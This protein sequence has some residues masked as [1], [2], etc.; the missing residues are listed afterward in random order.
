M[1]E[2]FADWFQRWDGIRLGYSESSIVDG[3]NL[4]CTLDGYGSAG[5]SSIIIGGITGRKQYVQLTGRGVVGVDSEHGDLLWIYNRIANDVA[6]TPTPIVKGDYI[7][8][9]PGYGTGAALIQIHDRNGKYEVEE[10]YFLKGNEL[11][12]HHGGMLLVTTNSL[13]LTDTDVDTLNDAQTINSLDFNHRC[14]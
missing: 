9:S 5:Y 3:D 7:F 10:K 2:A 12:N 14:Y 1:E 8:Y 13:Q 6:N 4:I 11:Q